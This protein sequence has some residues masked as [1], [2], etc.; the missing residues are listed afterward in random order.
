M[1]WGVVR[2]GK[3]SGMEH[4]VV[5]LLVYCGP[6]CHGVRLLHYGDVGGMGSDG[7][8]GQGEFPRG[9]WV[10]GCV[11]RQSGGGVEWFG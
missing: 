6:V 11:E 2:S 4:G 3:V 8:F 10:H 5:G 1:G 9:G 7:R